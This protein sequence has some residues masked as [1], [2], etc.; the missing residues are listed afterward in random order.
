M[1]KL[2]PKTAI[3]RGISRAPCVLK[4]QG[5]QANLVMWVR[6]SRGVVGKGVIASGAGPSLFHLD[7]F[8]GGLRVVFLISSQLSPMTQSPHLEAWVS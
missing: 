1:S 5:S 2:Y 6:V 4:G 3:S 7:I 8:G